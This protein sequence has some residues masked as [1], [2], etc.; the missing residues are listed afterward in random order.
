MPQPHRRGNEKVTTIRFRREST[1]ADVI[2]GLREAVRRTDLILVTLVGDGN[3]V[4]PFRDRSPT[5]TASSWRAELFW[6]DGDSGR[7]HLEFFLRRA[8]LFLDCRDGVHVEART[9]HRGSPRTRPRP[10][11]A[12]GLDGAFGRIGDE[13]AEL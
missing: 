2:A 9:H 1:V 7:G 13:G 6:R 12:Y 3:S 5:E 11:A 10:R 4:Y 8:E